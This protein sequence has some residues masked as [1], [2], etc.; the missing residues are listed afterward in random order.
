[1]P[2]KSFTG[3]SAVSIDVSDATK[4]A[5]GGLTVS[6]FDLMQIRAA[7]DRV[8]SGRVFHAL[9]LSRRILSPSRRGI[10]HA[11]S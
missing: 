7:D 4:A 9:A 5:V 10:G 3:S 6:S 11:S 8:G 2:L 1:M